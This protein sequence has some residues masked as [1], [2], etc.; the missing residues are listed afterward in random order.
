[1][2]SMDCVPV[3]MIVKN[4]DIQ[5]MISSVCLYS[6]ATQER[7]ESFT[8]SVGVLGMKEAWREVLGCLCCLLT[9]GCS[10]EF[11]L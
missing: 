11:A 1:V 7:K 6:K 3:F 2:V 5:F 8:S 4:T 9:G 10:V